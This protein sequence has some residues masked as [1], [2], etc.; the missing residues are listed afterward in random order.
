MV[1]KRNKSR[2][3]DKAESPVISAT[4]P[5]VGL[6]D[7]LSL[8]LAGAHLADGIDPEEHIRELREGWDE[9]ETASSCN[10]TE[11]P[12]RQNRLEALLEARGIGAEMAKGIDLDEHLRQ[13]REG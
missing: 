11:V 5:G 13:V 8:R 7:L 9:S 10:T 12:P 4:E 3:T 2:L 1:R 6:G